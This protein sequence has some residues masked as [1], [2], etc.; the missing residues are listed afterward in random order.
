MTTR[1]KCQP[2]SGPHFSPTKMCLHRVLLTS[3]LWGRAQQRRRAGLEKSL[4]LLD[5]SWAMGGKVVGYS[6][7]S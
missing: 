5:S 6:W 2:R 3:A 7:P 1:E 4:E